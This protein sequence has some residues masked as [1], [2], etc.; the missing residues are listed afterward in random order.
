MDELATFDLQGHM[1]GQPVSMSG[2]NQS[3]V[4]SSLDQP[5][6]RLVCERREALEAPEFVSLRDF[7]EQVARS[8]P[9]LSPDARGPS[10][11]VGQN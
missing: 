2:V 9:P 8:L 6:V 10:I 4:H 5:L 3:F 7:N 11:S 1:I